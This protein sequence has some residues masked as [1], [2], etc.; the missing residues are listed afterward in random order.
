MRGFYSLQ[1]GGLMY[2]PAQVIGPGYHL[3]EQA[4]GDGSSGWLWFESED[5][6]QQ[7]FANAY[8][9]L[10]PE[11]IQGAED[12]KALASARKRQI[13]GLKSLVAGALMATGNTREEAMELGRQ[14]Y[15][16]HGDQIYAYE[17]G[18]SPGLRAA[19]EADDSPWLDRAI[20]AGTI[21]DIFLTTLPNDPTPPKRNP[22]ISPAEYDAIFTEIEGTLTM[23]KLRNALVMAL[24]LMRG[25][26]D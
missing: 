10:S 16:A 21:R 6:A 17:E 13:D 9:G 3:T 18:A 22:I 11:A 23:A 8:P 12:L 14:L 4:P 26:V 5:A 25:G 2:A 24:N 7:H 1:N 20:G 19:I 15:S